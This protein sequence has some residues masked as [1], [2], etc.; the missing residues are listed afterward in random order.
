MLLQRYNPFDLNNPFRELEKLLEGVSGVTEVEA[1]FQPRVNVK[2][3]E[4]AYHITADLPGVKK[5][6]ISIDV[7]NNKLIISGERKF[8]EKEEKDNY[9]RVE[10]RYGKFSRF[11]TLN[12]KIDVEN[13]DAS[14]EEGVL[15]VVLP[16][17]KKEKE[18][19][20]KIEIK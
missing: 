2:E 19:G 7:K 13:I 5:E 18:E 17:I 15:E 12:D 3:G 16:K 11:F 1:D 10:S 8:E 6:D 14:C 20:K 9:L 4:Y